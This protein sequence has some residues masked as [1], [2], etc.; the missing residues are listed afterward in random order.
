MGSGLFLPQAAAY[1]A[2][3]LV[4]SAWSAVPAL[5]LVRFSRPLAE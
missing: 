2:A 5:P 3:D 4:E 1:Q